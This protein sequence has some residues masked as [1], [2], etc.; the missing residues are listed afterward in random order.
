MNTTFV[1]ATT[2]LYN[3]NNYRRCNVYIIIIKGTMICVSHLII[4]GSV[5]KYNSPSSVRNG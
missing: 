3:N 5:V 1:I 4:K 2:L